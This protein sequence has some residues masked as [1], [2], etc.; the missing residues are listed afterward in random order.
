MKKIQQIFYIS[1]LFFT[2]TF[3]SC[4]PELKFENPQPVEQKNERKFKNKYQGTYLC[5][6]DN[7]ILTIKKD[8][9]IQEWHVM[10][11]LTRAQIDSIKEIELKEG[12]LYIEGNE[13]PFS[14]VFTGDT[15]LLTYNF[16]KIIF[17]LS[18]DQVLRYFK[19]MYFL[20]YK[21]SD[22]FWT[23]KT[24]T[25]D[26][27]GVL[28]FNRIY[29]GEEEINKIKKITSVEEITDN[30]GKVL[31]YKVKPTEKELKEIMKS[32]L[33]KEGK[34]FQKIKVKL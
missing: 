4:L 5:L 30:E 19:G 21:E 17:Q 22:D 20:N 6:S 25:L 16:S 33:F 18:D 1:I 34:R 28:V 2:F 27:E 13:V 7:S 15:A 10:T 32:D 12:L 29:G 9:I 31:N 14:I 11:K 8:K 26:K 23:V 3:T 24:V